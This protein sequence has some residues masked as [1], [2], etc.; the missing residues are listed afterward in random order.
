M[1]HLAHTDARLTFAVQ[2]GYAAVTG[3]SAHT[4]EIIVPAEYGG[5]P[6]TEIA[7]GAFRAHPHLLSVTLPDCLRRVGDEAFA[8]CRALMQVQAGTGLEHL[9]ARAFFRCISLRHLAFPVLPDADITTFA[10]CYQLHA[11]EEKALY[12]RTPV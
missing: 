6:V 1:P 5:L 2:G 8:D 10:G 11:T 7:P 12:R 4:S 3:C 9:G